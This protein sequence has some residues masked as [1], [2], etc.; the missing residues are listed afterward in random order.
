M[1]GGLQ[2]VEGH[3]QKR[4]DTRQDF[5]QNPDF[6]FDSDGPRFRRSLLGVEMLLLQG[7]LAFFRQ[8]DAPWLAAQP[9]GAEPPAVAPIPKGCRS[10]LWTAPVPPVGNALST[11]LLRAE[12]QRKPAWCSAG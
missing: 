2:L 3:R 12:G 7:F 5:V 1:H 11:T 10:A 9:R 4:Q 6:L 8:P